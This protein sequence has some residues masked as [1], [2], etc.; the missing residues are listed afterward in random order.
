[1][2]L[3]HSRYSINPIPPI[4]SWQ[5]IN[6]CRYAEWHLFQSCNYGEHFLRAA[7]IWWLVVTPCRRCGFLLCYMY[8]PEIIQLQVQSGYM[9]YDDNHI[10]L[11][12]WWLAPHPPATIY[13]SQPHHC[14]ILTENQLHTTCPLLQLIY[15]MSNFNMSTDLDCQ[16]LESQFQLS[17]RKFNRA[18][19]QMSLLDQRIKDMQV[20]YQRAIKNKK[21][22]TRY[23]LR[24]H[25]AV[26]TGVKMMF[27]EYASAQADKMDA[28]REKMENQ[29]YTTPSDSEMDYDSDDYDSDDSLEFW[30][31]P[32]HLMCWLYQ[33]SPHKPNSLS[34]GS[35]HT[36]KRVWLFSLAILFA[37][38]MFSPPLWAQVPRW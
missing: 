37:L 31:P 26:M 38:N 25:L 12:G 19:D 28:L 33:L 10:I 18:C 27:Y 7:A 20:R 14:F 17:N 2:W 4:I 1:M 9:Y 15:N 29:L 3:Q 21:N 32:V 23:T 5:S 13:T 30:S 6:N 35:P 11:I 8:R 36:P 24:Q 16:D 34:Q 22:A